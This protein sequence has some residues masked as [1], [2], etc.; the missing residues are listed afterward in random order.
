M[1]APQSLTQPGLTR[2]QPRYPAREQQPGLAGGHCRQEAEDS[3]SPLGRF[4]PTKSMWLGPG[5]L[6]DPTSLA[7]PPRAAILACSGNPGGSGLFF[8]ATLG[9]LIPKRPRPQALPNH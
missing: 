9:H 5:L 8:S 1:K 6:D 7:P 2:V 3:P 4:M